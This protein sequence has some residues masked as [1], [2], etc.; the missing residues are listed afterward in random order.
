M[1]AAYVSGFK[2]ASTA[3]TW[4]LPWS[5][6]GRFVAAAGAGYWIVYDPKTQSTAQSGD[7][8]WAGQVGAQPGWSA[9]GRGQY[10]QGRHTGIVK[11]WDVASNQELQTLEPP[12]TTL[13][14]L[15]FSPDGRLL[16][17]AH[18]YTIGV[19]DLQTNHEIFNFRGHSK[20]INHLA[21]RPDGRRLA[22]AGSDGTVRIW[23]TSPLEDEPEPT[24]AGRK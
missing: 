15:I 14:D 9:F 7:E 21:F 18:D 16:A 6:D 8:R 2:A 10:G 1:R 22:S 20:M 23:D 11:I 19:W 13:R 12:N 5:L 17:L 4:A 3:V 24:G